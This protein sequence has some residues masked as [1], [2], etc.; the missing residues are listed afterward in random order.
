MGW[1]TPPEGTEKEEQALKEAREAYNHAVR[2]FR[3]VR[4][5]LIEFMNE[6]IERGKPKIQTCLSALCF[7]SFFINS[8]L[9]AG[10][11]DKRLRNE[12]VRLMSERFPGLLEKGLARMDAAEAEE[13]Q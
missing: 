9:F 13:K 4:P 10:F 11:K 8:I 6:A 12:A 7:S 3:A 2:L 1:S 5:G